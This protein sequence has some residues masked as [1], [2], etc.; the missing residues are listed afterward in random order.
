MNRIAFKLA[1]S[2][3]IVSMTM[4]AASSSLAAMRG[5]EVGRR[6]S[7]ASDRQ[8]AQLH[9]QASRALQQGQL[10]QAIDLMEQAVS[11][12]PRDVGYRMLLADA[13]LKAG[14]LDSARAT[15]GDVV[16]LDPSNIRGGLSIALIQIAQGRPQAAIGLLDDLSGRAPDADVGLAYALAGASE[17]AIAVL[18]P[19]ARAATATPR[20]RQN[21]ALA[22]AISG[23]WRRARAVAAQDVSPSDLDQRMTQWAAFA[24][25]GAGATQVA[26]MLG[27]TPIQDAGQ[28]VRLALAPEVAPETALADAAPAP[29]PVPEAAPVQTFAEAAPAPAPVQVAAAEAPA[30]VWVPTAQSWQAAPAPAPA[31]PTAPVLAEAPVPAA[32]APEVQERFADASRSLATPQPALRR[33]SFT[34]TAAPVFQRAAPGPAVRSGSAPVVVQLGAFSN[35]AN[36]ERAWVQASQRFALEGRNPLTTTINLNGRTLHRVSVSGFASA[37]DASRLC[38]AIRG[39]GGSCFVRGQAGDASIRWAARYANGRNRNA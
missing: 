32:P 19:A 31:A 8:A 26:S 30:P 24:R 25:P 34:P 37:A 7:G 1:A 39:Q 35:E 3:A 14:R 38:G 11:L 2:S 29:A 5:F 17:R 16:S 20:V 13:Y 27:V 9:Q 18:E 33:A 12:S 23:D 21:L 15:Y 10:G 36:A 6:A 4:L 22:Y 28:P